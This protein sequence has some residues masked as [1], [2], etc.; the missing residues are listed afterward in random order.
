MNR[1]REPA[2]DLTVYRARRCSRRRA[3]QLRAEFA[4]AYMDRL[5]VELR[6]S[7]AKRRARWRLVSRVTVTIVFLIIAGTVTWIS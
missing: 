6:E 4:M 1:S 5:T 7:G 3:R 2:I